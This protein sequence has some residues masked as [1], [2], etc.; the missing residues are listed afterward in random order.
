MC[1]S[2]L[3]EM[4]RAIARTRVFPDGGKIAKQVFVWKGVGERNKLSICR[5]ITIANIV[6]KLAE[7]CIKASAMGIWTKSGFPRPYWGHFFGAPE[8]LYVWLSTT[9]KYFRLGERPITILTDVSRAFDRFHH[10]LYKRKLFDYGL[11]N[12]VIR[13]VIEFISGLRL[14]ICWEKQRQSC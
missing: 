1:K 10:E 7:S 8:S 6:H 5:T 3:S 9:E 14:N 2:P 12:Q 11:S 13:L 4:I